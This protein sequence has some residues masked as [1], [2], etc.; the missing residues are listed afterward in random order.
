MVNFTRWLKFRADTSQSSTSKY[1]EGSGVPE[2][3]INLPIFCQIHGIFV[4]FTQPLTSH[5]EH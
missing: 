3:L 2:I 4:Q 5:A 1:S